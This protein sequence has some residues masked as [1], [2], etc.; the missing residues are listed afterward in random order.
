MR[1]REFITLIGGAATWPLAARAQQP[2]LPVIGFLNS[3]SPEGYAPYVAAFRQGLKET[4]YIEGQNAMIEYRWAEGHYDRLPA[5]AAD[6]VSRK[7]AVLAATSTPAALAAKATTSTIPIVFTT[8]ND[9]IKVGLVASLNRPEGNLTGVSSILTELG[10]KRLAL[11]RELVPRMT[12]VG[13]LT[14]PNFQDAEGQLSDME[15]AARALALQLVVLR[16]STER[17]IDAAFAAVTQRGG[18]ALIVATDPF[19]L[20]VRDHIIALAV[21]H[22]IPV[23]YPVRGYAGAGGLMSYGTDFKDSYRQA[24]LYTG[25]IAKGEK[26]GDL[27]V[28]RSVKF[29]FVINLNAAKTL[30]LSVPNSMHLLADEMIE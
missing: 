23:M 6:L 16:A 1:R 29:E 5:M 25:R 17:E 10:S 24:G 26:P 18:G 21:R 27:Q 20:A 14:N 3:T 7:V 22:A 30:G 2:T 12:V 13:F 8:G 4:G 9:P 19:F 11:L 15:A 28:Q